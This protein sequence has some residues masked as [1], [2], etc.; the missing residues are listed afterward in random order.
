[1]NLFRKKARPQERR[2]Q[3]RNRIPGGDFEATLGCDDGSRHHVAVH[4]LSAGGAKVRMKP[5]GGGTLKAGD[6]VMLE[7]IVSNPGRVIRIMTEVRR[8]QDLFLHLEFLSP[9]FDDIPL[10]VESRML[11][12][13]RKYPRQRFAE[14]VPIELT[15]SN[16]VVS[17]SLLDIS[18]GGL[19]LRLDE[20]LAG[21]LGPDDEVGIRFQLPGSMSACSTSAIIRHRTMRN[22]ILIFGVAFSPS[23]EDELNTVF[24]FLGR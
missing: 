10:D 8:R 6:P 11:L 17:G 21:K 20:D 22:G 14:V 4:E 7:L 9:N 18:E 3:F 24:E 13:R 15:I 5:G 12:S 23:R 16:V 19:G 2:A 1:M